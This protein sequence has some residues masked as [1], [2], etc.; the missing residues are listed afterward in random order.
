MTPVLDLPLIFV[1]R[2][3]LASAESGEPFRQHGYELLARVG[4][5]S[6][7]MVAAVQRATP[8]EGLTLDGAVVGGLLVR[9]S[10]LTRGIFDAVQAHESEAHG[11]L[12]RCAAETAITLS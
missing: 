11:P 2:D 7:Q 6:E 5:M 3:L 4:Q 1:D 10:K 9:L 8:A 12:S